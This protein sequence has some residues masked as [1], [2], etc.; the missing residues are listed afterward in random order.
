MKRPKMLLGSYI[1]FILCA[2]LLAR[3]VSAEHYWID[4]GDCNQPDMAG[5][6]IDNG[7]VHIA[8]SGCRIDGRT[9]VAPGHFVLRLS[10][11]ASEGASQPDRRG[12]LYEIGDGRV[13][14]SLGEGFV[15]GRPCE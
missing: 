15:V 12:Q 1:A 10:G 8:E 4:K 7:H 2:P 11:C 13:V 3:E 6:S 5:F 14:L 9:Q